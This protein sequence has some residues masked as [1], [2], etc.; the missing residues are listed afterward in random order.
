MSWLIKIFT[1]WNGATLGTLLFTKRRGIKVGEDGQ[2]NIYYEEKS[3]P[4]GRRKRR[5]VTYNGT[6]EASRV[7]PDW[8]GW[9]HYTYDELPTTAPFEV[10]AWEK[11]HVANLTG[12]P[13]ACR[14]QGGL[15]SKGE[16]PNATGDY[17]AWQPE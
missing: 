14:P 6:A 17:E 7:P 12:T 3:R 8:H 13:F 4:G 1:W 9:L 15:A 16:R 5:W 11:E 2:G 10:K